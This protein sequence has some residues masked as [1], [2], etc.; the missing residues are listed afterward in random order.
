MKTIYS[1]TSKVQQG[2]R[3]TL[4]AEVDGHK[5]KAEVHVDTSYAEQSHAELSFLAIDGWS[6]LLRQRSTEVAF[7]GE[8]H[9]M[10]PPK[11]G[12]LERTPNAIPGKL[13][14]NATALV[15]LGKQIVG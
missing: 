2:V 15:K 12:E 1:H 3:A 5:F 10:V 13:I 6:V 11:R 8:W 7:A 9:G 14:A 4:I